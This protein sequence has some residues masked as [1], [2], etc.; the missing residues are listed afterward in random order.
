MKKSIQFI[1]L[2]CTVSWV[3]AGVA[4]LLGLREARGLIYTIF[5]LFYMLLPAFCAIILQIIHKEKPFR[6]LNVSFNWNSII[7]YYRR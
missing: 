3:I 1:V 6:N 2:T 7:V 4:I 5:G